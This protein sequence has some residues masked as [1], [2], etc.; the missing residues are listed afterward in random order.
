[1][2]FTPLE[3]AGA[4]AIDLEKRG[5]A[6]GYF[7]RVWCEDE[8]RDQ[9]LDGTRI[10][11][12]NTGFSRNR[13]TLRGMHYQTSPHAEVKIVRCLRG[14]VFDVVVD[15]RPDSPTFR[16]WSGLTLSAK[17][18]RAMYV[19]KGCA[20]GYLT[21]EDES[22]LMYTTSQKY[23]PDAATG[24]RFDDV[25]F[26]IEWPA[27]IEIVS[28]A[29]LSWPDFADVEVSDYATPSAVQTEGKERFR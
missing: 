18:G 5:D 7:A 8:M 26:G 2:Q 14:S 4:Y 3:V 6:R 13:G 16:R 17:S 12:I 29:D 24:V 10:A 11:Q 23:A 9:G 20:H 21:L 22:E 28:D 1:M 19:P 15:L 25:A 27:A